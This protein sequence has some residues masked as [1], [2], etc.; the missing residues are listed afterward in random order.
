VS[1]EKRAALEY[2]IFN[3]LINNCLGVQIIVALGLTA[4]GAANGAHTL[5]IV[6]DAVNIVMPVDAS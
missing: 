2:R 3:I 6:F 1:E 4:I 5:V